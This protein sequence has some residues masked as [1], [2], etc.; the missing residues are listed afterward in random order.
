MRQRRQS[1]AL[2]EI[3]EGASIC[4]SRDGIAA[5]GARVHFDAKDMKAPI[6]TTALVSLFL[7]PLHAQDKASPKGDPV[8]PFPA[9]L[10][11][12]ERFV[13]DLPK[14]EDESA[15]KVELLVG[16]MVM[17]DPGKKHGMAGEV[18]R[19]TLE[20]WGYPYLVVDSEGKMFNNLFGREP[21]AKKVEKFIPIGGLDL[22]RYNSKLPLV[23][24]TP[25]G[26]EVR[27]RI[28]S[29]GEEVKKAVKE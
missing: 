6:I 28:W 20:G 2:L 9:P 24:Y 7:L 10:E 5:I 15:A 22:Q 13:I 26:F 1:A 18:E 16:K 11:G 23:V 21:G 19:K 17:A 14:L 12:Q 3:A 4:F 29:A 8:H 27:Y 25:R